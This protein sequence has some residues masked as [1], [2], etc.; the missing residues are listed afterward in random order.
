MTVITNRRVDAKQYS[1]EH[2]NPHFKKRDVSRRTYG[3]IRNNST[4]KSLEDTVSFKG[5]Q[6]ERGINKLKNHFTPIVI[7]PSKE[8]VQ[9]VFET[10]DGV[11]SEQHKYYN[12]IRQRFV[13]L[14]KTDPKFCQKFGINKDII[15]N[16]SENNLYFIPKDQVAT[17]FL[18]NLVSPFTFIVK[19]TANIFINKN[20]NK[21]KNNAYYEKTAREYKCLE[22]L[23]RSVEIW[24]NE[25]RKLS[26]L[27][28]RGKRDDFVIPDEV[29]YANLNRRRNKIVDPTKGKYSS[30]SLMIGNR[31]ISG[32]VYAYFLGNDAYNTTMRYSNNKEE[33]A[34][35]RKSRIAQEFSRIGLNMYI[36]N[37][38]FGTLESSVNKS[39]PMALVVSGSTTAFSEILGRKLVGKP[40]VPSNKETLDRMEAEMQS[41]TGILPAIGK[42]LTGAKK[43]EAPGIQTAAMEFQDIKNAPNSSLFASFSTNQTQPAAAQASASIKPAASSNPSFKGFF[44]NDRMFNKQRILSLLRILEEADYKQAQFMKRTLLNSIKYSDAFKDDIRIQAYLKTFLELPKDKKISDKEY[45]LLFDT[46]LRN[47]SDEMPIGKAKTLHGQILKSILVP[48]NWVKNIIYSV[49]KWSSGYSASLSDKAVNRYSR[50]FESNKVKL[51]EQDRLE[52]EAYYNFYKNQYPWENN[53]MSE[54][55]KRLKLYKEYIKKREA[56]S[57]DI[58]GAKNLLLLIEKEIKSKD[59]KIQNDGTLSQEDVTKLREIL[60]SIVL[61]ADG[62]RHVEYDGNALSQMNV[63]LGRAITTIFLVTDAFNLTMQYSNDDK[64]AARKSAKNRT[65]QE[66][67]RIGLSA[68]MLAFVHNLLAKICNSSLA[69]AFG[70]TALTSVI[71]D[72]LSRKDVGVPITPKTKEE[73]TEIDK[74]NNRSK[75]PIKKALAYSLGKKSAIPASIKP[76]ASMPFFITPAIEFKKP[77]A[78]TKNN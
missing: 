32:M 52:M 34:V 31:F 37:L 29:L 43:K 54:N 57:E 62:A 59:I 73:L 74:K 15:D 26:G 50:T 24:E 4:K 46:I 68:Y 76:N 5:F 69:G 41:K 77:P 71:N 72:S 21:Y 44:I 49:Q 40:I 64:K 8:L 38:L 16:I 11:S 20:S 39:L 30:T 10:L 78:G 3:H 42:L 60:K 6:V 1:L 28:S 9:K 7:K 47:L 13:Q 33:A 63:N 51:S 22:G 14:V 19:K 67:S 12:E 61:K 70:I 65:A 2:N 36:Q 27:R 58:E 53:G 56:V 45:N 55:L 48:V 18:K 66:I 35:Q 25:Y 23:I 75:S 17:K